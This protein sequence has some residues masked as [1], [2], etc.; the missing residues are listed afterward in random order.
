MC[1]FCCCC[2][3]L[4]FGFLFLFL[5]FFPPHCVWRC[6]TLVCFYVCVVCFLCICFYYLYMFWGVTSFLFLTGCWKPVS[7]FVFMLISFFSCDCFSYVYTRL[8][9]S[10]L[11]INALSPYMP[12]I[13]YLFATFDDQCYCQK[14]V[15]VVTI[16][17]CSE[18][19]LHTIPTIQM[20]F[21]Q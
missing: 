2:W 19:L 13:Q 1:G 5:F 9:W 12:L 7:Q 21:W 14:L 10:L 11:C 17:W 20:H 3:C 6:F 15:V 16:T 18:V 8:L 4:V